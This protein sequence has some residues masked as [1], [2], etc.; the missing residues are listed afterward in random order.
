LNKAARI[1]GDI[2]A[3]MR[4]AYLINQYPAISHTFIRREI[5]ALESLNVSVLRYAFRRQPEILVDIEDIIEEKETKY[6]T[7]NVVRNVIVATIAAIRQPISIIRLAGLAIKVGWNSDSGLI[8]NFAY[9]AEALVVAHWCRRDGIEHVHAHFGTNSATVA[10]LANVLTRIPYSFTV[11]GPEEFERA[12]FLSLE[13]KVRHA[14]FVVC[15]SSFGKSQLMRWSSFDLW[16]KIEVVHC[17]V[18][19]NFY[20]SPVYSTHSPCPR[21]VCVGRLVEQKAHLLIL[22][23]AA[24]L[25][26]LGLIF[27]IVF[28]GDGRMRGAIQDE[29]SRAGLEL[30]IT[31]LGSVSGDRVKAEIIA[32][33]A[34]LSASF[35]EG[36]PVV[37][38]E[39]MMLRRPV[40]ATY[41]AGIPELVENR[42]NGWLI[43][44]G[45]EVALTDAMREALAAPTEQLESMGA[46]AYTRA[47]ERHDAVTEAGKLKKLFEQYKNKELEGTI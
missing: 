44:A 15:I 7:D 42:I 19:S 27:Q 1:I 45:D 26:K 43:P 24:R 33:R 40:I 37:I 32:A 28:L 2:N 12:K 6:I 39:A 20:N 38:M 21:F 10:M 5:R 41:I 11:H 30:P 17:G 13:E 3:L 25:Q 36:L 34:L 4:I 9:A 23:A 47:I 16:K 35:A 29:I 22:A 18:D 14:A 31:L 8:R 46:A